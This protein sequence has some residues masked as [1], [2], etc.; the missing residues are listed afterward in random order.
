MVV[1]EQVVAPSAAKGHTSH[2]VTMISIGMFGI[3]CG[4]VRCKNIR[5]EVA[6]ISTWRK[7][8]IGA[9]RLTH[10]GDRHQRRKEG[11]RLVIERCQLLG[12]LPDDDN[13]ADAAGIW[14]W[15]GATFMGRIPEALHL[16]GERAHG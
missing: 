12:W 8:F 15:A 2:D 5:L 9:G 3:I 4:I 11:K 6:Q 1:I 13:Q 14:D 10:I 7:H 16:F